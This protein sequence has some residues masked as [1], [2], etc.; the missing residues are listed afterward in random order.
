MALFGDNKKGKRPR[1][2]PAYLRVKDDGNSP[3]WG[4]Q[5]ANAQRSVFWN[6]MSHQSWNRAKGKKPEVRRRRHY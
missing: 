1:V 4:L 6:N 3:L 2:V 5:V